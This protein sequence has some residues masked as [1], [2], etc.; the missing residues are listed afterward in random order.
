MR[1]TLYEED[2]YTEFIQRNGEDLEI[3]KPKRA[4]IQKVTTSDATGDISVEG[5][6]YPT[7]PIVPLYNTNKQSELKGNREA[8]DALDMMMSGLVNNVDS[9][10]VVYW[11]LKNSGGFDQVDMNR[12]IQTLKAT[13]V[14]MIDNEDDVTP[15]SPI[16]QFQASEAAIAQLRRQI[17]DNHM[18]FDAKQVQAGAATATEIRAAYEPLNAKTDLLEFHVTEFINGILAVFGIDD[19]PTYTRSYII[20]QNEAIQTILSAGSDLPQ[21]YKL[22]KILEILGDIDRADEVLAMI[23]KEEMERFEQAKMMAELENTAG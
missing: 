21:E 4:Y 22:K 23:Q 11:L 19:D 8:H 10:E 20:N 16:V 18:G 1:L 5:M 13:H 9:G 7:F 14:A 17:F 3:L 15:H 6:N 2:G 12:F